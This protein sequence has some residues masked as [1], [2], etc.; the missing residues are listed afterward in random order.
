MPAQLS[1]DSFMA[2]LMAPDLS[3]L[4]AAVERGEADS[5]LPGFRQATDF[6]QGTRYHALSCLRHSAAVAEMVPA[7]RVERVTAIFHDL[8]KG[9]CRAPNAR[10]EE[11]YIG[12]ADRGSVMVLPYLSALGVGG[13]DAA[14]V[15]RRIARHM[16]LHMAGKD[17]RSERSLD[18]VIDRLGPD[19]PALVTLAAAD[20]AS[21]HPDIAAEKLAEH[22]DLRQRLRQRAA[23]RGMD[24][25][26]WPG[27]ERI[28][29]HPAAIKA[30]ME[31]TAYRP[32]ASRDGEEARLLAAAG[33]RKGATSVRAP[34]LVVVCGLQFS[35]KSVFARVLESRVSSAVHLSSDAFRKALTNGRPTYGGQESAVTH[36]TVRRMTAR[37]LDAGHSVIVDS[38]GIKA[39]D[40]RASLECAR[41]GTPT[42]LVWCECS[43]EVAKERAARRAKRADPYDRSDA[44]LEHRAKYAGSAD[45][46]GPGEAAVVLYANPDNFANMLGKAEEFLLGR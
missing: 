4:A 41:A 1:R 30:V 11:S 34:R 6:I 25:R 17:A 5:L 14:T 28:G 19:L 38:T 29:P 7:E 20:T 33:V 35:G 40:R 37:L 10:G 22:S 16:D 46:P 18:K 39:R 26:L 15:V 3:P 2:M 42:M 31:G 24:L 23:E 45:R 44:T 21:M 36:G 9:P 27:V 43:D 13:D 32:A 8:G 12:H